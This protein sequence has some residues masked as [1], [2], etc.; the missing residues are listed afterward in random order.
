M[1][2]V[3]GY[4]IAENFKYTTLTRQVVNRFMSDACK[5]HK[6]YVVGEGYSTPSDLTWVNPHFVSYDRATIDRAREL[7]KELSVDLLN[8]LNSNRTLRPYMHNFPLTIANVKLIIA[9]RD[10]DNHYYSAVDPDVIDLVRSEGHDVNYI[11]IS[12][13]GITREIVYQEPY[14]E[15]FKQ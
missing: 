3:S 5:K 4:E 2:E 6:L 12:N 7:F 9:F 15:L 8:R 10:S 1:H 11:R 14:N 13:G